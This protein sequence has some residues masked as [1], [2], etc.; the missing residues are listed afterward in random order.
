MDHLDADA[1]VLD[2][3][4]RLQAGRG[5]GDADPSGFHHVDLLLF[6]PS[7]DLGDIA[8]EC[9][10]GLPRSIRSLARSFGAEGHG[11]SEFL[12]Y[13][14]FDPV[15]TGRLVDLGLEDGRREWSRIE[16]LMGESLNHPLKQS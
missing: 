2:R 11:G 5:G 14:L 16:R 4:N 1:E 12:S 15:Y 6:R 10:D 3:V 9:A 8:R 13:L 7:R